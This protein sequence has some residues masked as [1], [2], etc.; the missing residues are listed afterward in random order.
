MLKVR[1]L[2]ESVKYLWLI[3]EFV[4]IL[5]IILI[6]LQKIAPSPI[7]KMLSVEFDG[8][9]YIAVACPAD[10]DRKA[11]VPERRLYFSG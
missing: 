11:L 6:F 7:G 8:F 4:N 3:A 5:L 10:Q 9:P 2:R 1:Y